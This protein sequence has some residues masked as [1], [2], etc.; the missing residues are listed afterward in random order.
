MTK[1]P[2]ILRL[3]LAAASV[4]GLAACGRPHHH[5]VITAKVIDTIRAGEVRWNEDLKSGNPSKVLAHYGADAQVILPDAPP[6]VGAAALRAMVASSM[7]D[8]HF[9]LSFSSDSVQVPRS[10]EFAVVKGTYATTNTDPK[11][12]AVQTSHGAFLDVY[13]P[14][15]DGRWLVVWQM[16][17]PDGPSASAPLPAK[18]S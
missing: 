7:N 13:R 8:P 16:T 6:V 4:L 11:T 14:A 15:G 18:S 2:T 5:H 10:G 12:Q 3:A 9:R 17:A 1:A